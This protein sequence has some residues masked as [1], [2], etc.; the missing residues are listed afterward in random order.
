MTENKTAGLKAHN[1]NLNKIICESLQQALMFLMNKQAFSSISITALCKKA[2][3][4]R[5]AF[6]N[7]Y[8]SKEDLLEKIVLEHV[9]QLIEKIGSPFRERTNAEWYE[10]MF[11]C[12]KQDEYYLR[13][14]FNAG[15]KHEYLAII[16]K[17]VLHNPNLTPDK[18]YL[19]IAW[20]GGISN[21][22]IF[23]LEN[24]MSEPISKIAEFCYENLS[25]WA[26]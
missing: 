6:Y 18:K 25:V 3:V 19:R 1:E 2:G 11:E 13:T 4:S 23:W 26:N 9:K 15:F 7:N 14:I 5:M 24:G 10:K 17:V 22:I 8:K 21:A 16:N 12:V 20:A